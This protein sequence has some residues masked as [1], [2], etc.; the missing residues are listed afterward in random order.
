[1]TFTDILPEGMPG[2]PLP[3]LLRTDGMITIILFLCFILVSSV[4][5]RGSKHLLQGLKNFT[6]N[7]E[8]SNLFD[9]VTAADARHTFFLVLHTCTMMGICVYHY[10]S[11]T[12]PILFQKFSRPLLFTELVAGI[13][14]FIFIK[15]ILY[16][17][18]NWVFFQKARNI[19]WMASFF[20]L[21][22]WFGILLLPIVLLTVYFDISSETSF[23]LV[24]ILLILAKMALFWKCFSNFFE[25]IYGVFHLI[26]YFCALEIL[27]DLILWKGMEQITNILIF[28]L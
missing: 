4:F 12:T 15:W 23:I 19:I 28:K 9:E 11:H 18:V 24:A 25:K 17:A 2:E 3:Y 22:I 13:L 21:L 10:L 26:L 16:N 7:R 1:M 14:L 5:S 6:Q 27:P 8:R 20:N